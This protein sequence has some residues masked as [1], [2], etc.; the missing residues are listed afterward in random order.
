MGDTANVSDC[1][2]SEI[3]TVLLKEDIEF[4]L[5]FQEIKQWQMLQVENMSLKLLPLAMK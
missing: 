1:S 3:V 2:C 4:L 5:S